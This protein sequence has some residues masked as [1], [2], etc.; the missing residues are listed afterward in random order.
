LGARFLAIRCSVAL[1]S[2]GMRPILPGE[3]RGVFASSSS[4]PV[5]RSH[6]IVL[7]NFERQRI[8]ARRVSNPSLLGNEKMGDDYLNK[9]PT[10]ALTL[11]SDPRQDG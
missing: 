1:S 3:G 10:P 7:N 4:S 6:K 5:V 2:W 8:N 9:F 11:F